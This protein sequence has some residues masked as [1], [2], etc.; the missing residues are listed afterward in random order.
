MNTMPNTFRVLAHLGESFTVWLARANHGMNSGI[1][2]TETCETSVCPART[3]SREATKPFW[4][5]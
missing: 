4:M 1:S 3:Q 2:A 5:A